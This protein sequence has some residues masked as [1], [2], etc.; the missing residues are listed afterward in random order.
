MDHFQ[1]HLRN[2]NLAPRQLQANRAG[3]LD[4]VRPGGLGDFKVL[5]QGKN[6]GRPVLWGLEQSPEATALVDNLPVPV[7]TGRHLSLPDGRYPGG[8]IDIEAF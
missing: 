5:A 7:L 4:L 3:I 6:V 2:Q 8:E 1:R